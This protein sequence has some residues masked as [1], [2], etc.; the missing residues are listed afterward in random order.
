MEYSPSLLPD[1]DFKDPSKWVFIQLDIAGYGKGRQFDRLGSV[2]L[3]SVEVLRT[4]NEEPSVNGTNWNFSKEMNKYYDLFRTNRTL[5]FD[6][7][8]IVNDVY[9]SPLDYTIT[10]TAYIA[11]GNNC[12]FQPLSKSYP[13][14]LPLSKKTTDANAFFS[15]GDDLDGSEGVTKLTIPHNA[16]TALVEIYA[17]GTAQDEFWYT[18][19]PNSV[20]NEIGGAQ[21]AVAYPRGPLRELQVLIDGKLAGIAQPF[22]VIFTGGISPFF[23]RPQVAYGAFDQPTYVIDIT[24]FLGTLTDDQEHEFALKVVSAEQNQTVLAWFIS[25]NVQVQLDSSNERT[26][27][28]ITQYIAPAAGKYESNNVVKGNVSE[29]GTISASIRTPI[30]Q[31]RTILIEGT[32]KLG[33]SPVPIPVSWKQSITYSNVN[34]LSQ[35]ISSTLQEAEGSFTSQHGGEVVLAHTFSYPFNLTSV[36][37]DTTLEHGYHIS[38]SYGPSIASTIKEP[39]NQKVDMTQNGLAVTIIEGN[40]PTA[41]GYGETMTSYSYEDSSGNTFTRDNSVSHQAITHDQVGGSLA[42]QAGPV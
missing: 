41:N 26:T 10:L 13:T 19:I 37:N 8:N 17:S 1:N 40:P 27:G 32:I 15:L 5:L 21:N 39:L 25:G 23:W 36:G 35:N 20:Y 9:V 30:D 6:L 22:P 34:D 4:D 31:P 38:T 42:S 12:K 18:N 16:R 14:I 24:P 33:S 3:D 11:N 2:Q 7:P 28:S 29:N